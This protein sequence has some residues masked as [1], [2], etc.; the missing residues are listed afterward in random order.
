MKNVKRV[1]ASLFTMVSCSLP[2]MAADT[3]KQNSPNAIGQKDAVAVRTTPDSQVLA[4][5]TDRKECL[6]DSSLNAT[7]SGS[8]GTV[9]SHRE[10]H[11][12]LHSGDIFITTSSK[13]IFVATAQ[14]GC[15]LPA[16]CTAIVR[17]R[18]GSTFQTQVV[19]SETAV[20]IKLKDGAVV[21]LNERE[22]LAVTVDDSITVAKV[23]AFD[24]SNSE[25]L[26]QATDEEP[27]R[28]FAQSGSVFSFNKEAGV[29]L[30]SG[31][32]MI[33]A[34][35]PL[36]VRTDN[37]SF[38]VDED[39]Y[40]SVEKFNTRTRVHALNQKDCLTVSTPVGTAKLDCGRELLITE[41]ANVATD[42]LP[43]DGVG[44]RVLHR[45]SSASGCTIIV[46][47]YSM[48][49]LLKYNPA[50][51][52]MRADSDAHSKVILAEL[53]KDCAAVE[54][55]TASHGAYSYAH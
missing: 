39:E 13:P 35:S 53:I 7:I 22:Q 14:A 9:V 8:A 28:I 30:L 50:A 43:Y 5:F 46:S 37:A 10:D 25:T 27:A 41:T 29:K 31:R 21:T 19:K 16:N 48:L 45:V 3:D 23:S 52:A 51:R 44:R 26:S 54:Y 11:Y 38:T 55:I 49:G 42:S 1:L 15:K 4:L 32:L 20:A 36:H 12:T 33:C 40:V 6:K 17:Y 18:P 24:S 2:V 47:E 34:E